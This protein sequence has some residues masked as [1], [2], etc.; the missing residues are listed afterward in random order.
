VQPV[1]KRISPAEA[2]RRRGTTKAP[3][4]NPNFHHEEHEDHEDHEEGRIKIIGLVVDVM[5]LPQKT[6]MT[7]M[8]FMVNK[9]CCLL[10]F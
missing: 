1:S 4:L 10:I 7:F 8:R 9:P 2:R 5:R 6:F 3:V